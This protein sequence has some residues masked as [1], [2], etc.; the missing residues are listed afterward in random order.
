MLFPSGPDTPPNYAEKIFEV[1]DKIEGPHRTRSVFPYVTKGG[2]SKY[3]VDSSGND[4][5][6]SC[7]SEWI[8]G[9]NQG[10]T[11]PEALQEL[12]SHRNIHPRLFIPRG[13][14]SK[15]S[16]SRPPHIHAKITS[17]E[18]ETNPDQRHLIV[19]SANVTNAALGPNPTNYEMGTLLSST[20]SLT[21][22]SLNAFDSWWNDIWSQSIDVSDNLIDDYENVKADL[23]ED[24]PPEATTN[25]G[26]TVAEANEAKFLWIETGSMQGANRYI[27]EIKEEIADFFEEKSDSGETIDIE[28]RGQTYLGRRLGIHTHHYAPQWR[29]F[30]PTDFT[31]FDES[32]YP[33]Q[34]VRFEK[35]YDSDG[36]SHYRLEIRPSSHSDVNRWRENSEKYGVY[37][38]TSSGSDGREYGYY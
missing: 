21:E 18:S 2:I 10:I 19:T 35:I 22:D 6:T 1:L 32:Y 38:V 26:H 4:W 11:H 31:T 34:V 7:D 27:L 25:T 12:S 3:C 20:E 24:Q 14:I 37:N 23:A 8:I 16:L 13:S 36:I 29:V 30:M 28:F 33:Y 9:L 5:R 17:I 15:E